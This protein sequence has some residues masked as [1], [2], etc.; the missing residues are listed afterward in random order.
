MLT[1]ATIVLATLAAISS[2]SGC[3]GGSSTLSP[4]D[5]LTGT[6]QFMMTSRGDDGVSGRA[7]QNVVIAGLRQSF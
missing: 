2:V 5:S 7:V 3:G 4:G 1:A 6:L